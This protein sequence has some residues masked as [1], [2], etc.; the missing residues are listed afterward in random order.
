MDG[1]LGSAL[2]L[3]TKYHVGSGQASRIDPQ[4]FPSI[5]RKIGFG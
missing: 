1:V 5:D 4:T 2:I 3:S